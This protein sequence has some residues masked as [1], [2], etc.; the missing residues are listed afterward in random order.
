MMDASDVGP[1]DGVMIAFLPTNSEWSTLELPHLTLVYAGSK[2]DLGA[3][4]FSALVKDAAALALLT[5]PFSLQVL[6]V[7]M[8]G[9][10]EPVKV[11]RF[12]ATPELMAARRYVDG[13]NK[14]EFPFKPHSTIGP[15]SNFVDMI[16]R[17]VRFDKLCVAWGPEV[18]TFGLNSSY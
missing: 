13:W 6:G 2:E 17:M 4:D 12:R 8:F 9:D 10:T 5:H 18:I 1:D 15:A 7:E 11:L 16:P 14:S 3:S